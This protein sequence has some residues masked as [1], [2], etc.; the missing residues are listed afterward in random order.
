MRLRDKK[1]A[2]KSKKTKALCDKDGKENAGSGGHGV[3]V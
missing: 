3:I 2:A 1:F